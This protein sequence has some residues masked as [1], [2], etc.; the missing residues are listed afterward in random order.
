MIRST[1]KFRVTDQ[2]VSG[3]M[4][5]DDDLN[6][7]IAQGRVYLADYAALAWPVDGAI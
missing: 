3:V 6:T 7:A 5:T 4:G 1:A 2:A